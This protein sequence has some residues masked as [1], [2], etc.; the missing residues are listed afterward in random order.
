MVPYVH[1]FRRWR[2]FAPG[3]HPSRRAAIPSTGTAAGD[4]LPPYRP[5]EA[6]LPSTVPAAGHKAPPYRPGEA[7]IP[8]N[9]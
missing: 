3:R 6:A 9:P 4:K 2:G 1:V 7:A 8:R 5:G